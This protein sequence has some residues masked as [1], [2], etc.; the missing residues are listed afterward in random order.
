MRKGDFFTH[1][2]E[3]TKRLTFLRKGTITFE[4]REEFWEGEFFD[5]KWMDGSNKD[6]LCIYKLLGKVV[7]KGEENGKYGVWKCEDTGKEN[8]IAEYIC[9][10]ETWEK[11]KEEVVDV[12]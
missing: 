1:R 2:T 9:D 6:V 7:K 10:A 5:Y 11:E 3:G 8:R 4:E 12:D